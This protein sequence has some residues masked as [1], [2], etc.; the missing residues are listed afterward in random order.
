MC[1]MDVQ[2]KGTAF[3]GK[4][5]QKLRKLINNKFEIIVRYML[6]LIR[7]WIFICS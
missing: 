4:I 5:N 1:P 6:V 7:V 3:Y 2:T